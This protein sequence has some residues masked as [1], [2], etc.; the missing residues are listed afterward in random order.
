MVVKWLW[1]SRLGYNHLMKDKITTIKDF[2]AKELYCVVS[3]AGIDN[4]PESALV[5][6]SE[7]S[8][9]EIIFGTSTDTR[10]A[11]NI[12][13]NPSTS[14]V[15][16]LHGNIS[17][18]LEG[19]ARIIPLEESGKYAEIHYKKQPGSKD[20]MDRPGECFVVVTVSWVRYTDISHH[21]ENV[22]EVELP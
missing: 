9:L 20:Y 11:I 7:S 17:I 8:D 14:I 22:F 10:K 12:L 13:N 19:R 2:V 16:G 6:F 5:A 18:Q 3:T 1:L 21:P 4:K 15:I